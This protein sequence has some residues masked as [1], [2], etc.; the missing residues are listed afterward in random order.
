MTYARPACQ[1]VGKILHP[2]IAD[3]LRLG[4]RSNRVNFIAQMHSQRGINL[5]KDQLSSQAVIVW[6]VFLRQPSWS[7]RHLI[8]R[9]NDDIC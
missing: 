9:K 2:F 1:S 5:N 3:P 7:Y 6:K 4:L 8:V